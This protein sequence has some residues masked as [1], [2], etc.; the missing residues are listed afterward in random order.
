MNF[1]LK[2][3]GSLSFRLMIM[4]MVG[5]YALTE[6][7]QVALRATVGDQIE[8]NTFRDAIFYAD[9]L[10]DRGSGQIDEE[11]AMV[12]A[13]VR[14]FDILLVRGDAMWSVGEPIRL[15]YFDFDAVDQAEIP[16]PI[17]RRGR[18]PIDSFRTLELNPV[19]IILYWALSQILRIKYSFG[20]SFH[21]SG[22]WHCC[23]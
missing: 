7:M 10:V 13:E 6:L 16:A 14:G 22:Y 17:L 4:F 2:I 20:A 15:R 12:L 5:G 9:L 11:L 19:D 18:P 3:S 23:F 1:I 8:Q 21:L